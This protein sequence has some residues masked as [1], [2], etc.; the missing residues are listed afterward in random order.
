MKNYLLKS[1]LIVLIFIAVV[2]TLS[3]VKAEKI[4]DILGV[5][6]VY[7][8]VFIFAIIGGVS[9]FSASS[10]YATVFSLASTGVNPFMLALFS[11]P[12]VLIGDYI[13]WYIGSSGREAV[14]VKY[15]DKFNH[16]FL[17]WLNERPKWLV[18]VVIYIYTGLTPFPGDLLMF[19]LAFMGYK[20]KQIWIPTLLGNYTLALI[21]SLLAI[22]GLEIFG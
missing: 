18:S 16:K 10:F 12:G 2:A 3:Y 17:L 15:N 7:L 20:F 8:I 19:I 9:A 6:N 11:A 14:R 1:I 4:V 5:S 21:V 13:F 22:Y